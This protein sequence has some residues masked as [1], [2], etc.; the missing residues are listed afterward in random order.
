MTAGA[1]SAMALA[2][3][4]MAVP[5]IAAAAERPSRHQNHERGS[6]NRPNFN[7]RT[8][9]SARASAQAREAWSR[10]NARQARSGA[11]DMTESRQRAI[12]TAREQRR[13]ESR[14]DAERSRET[15]QQRR[16]ERHEDR[17]ERRDNRSNQWMK[18][19]QRRDNR[20][21]R[22]DNRY[23]RRDDRR[24]DRYD[25]RDDRRDHRYEGRNDRR[26]HRW[27]DRNDRREYRDHRRWDRHSWR[28]NNRYDW[29][30]YRARH[31]ST[32]RIGRYYAPYYGYSYRRLGIGFTLGSMFYSNRYWIDD[33]WM[34]RLP[35]VYGPYR[36]VRYY[37]D[38]LLVNVYTGEVVDVIYDFFW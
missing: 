21:D 12:R 22:R 37:D 32:Y 23:D 7:N 14:R 24:D 13:Q 33:P 34:Y 29:R 4:S 11:P 3:A 1:W 8:Q 15:W 25:R 26:D 19:Y 6:D 27:S 31:R 20:D 28:R 36:W 30:D 5:D 9:G 38:V 16:A 10:N 35:E 17:A 2:V 18:Q